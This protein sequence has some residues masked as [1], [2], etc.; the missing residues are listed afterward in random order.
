MVDARNHDCLV[1]EISVLQNVWLEMDMLEFVSCFVQFF[2][3][4][5]FGRG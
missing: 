5:E 4:S 3:W 2:V 1:E